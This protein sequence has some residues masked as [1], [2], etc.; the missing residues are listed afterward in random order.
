MLP[1][2]AAIAPRTKS[3]TLLVFCAHTAGAPATD[4]PTRAGAWTF[5]L[6]LAALTLREL[7]QA[8]HSKTSTIATA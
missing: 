3:S 1:I 2:E 7:A 4:A 5:A 8:E 6:L